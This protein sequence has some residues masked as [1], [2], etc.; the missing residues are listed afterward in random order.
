MSDERKRATADVFDR[1]AG[2]YDQLGVDFFTPMGRD[3][4]DRAELRPG[5]R[6][7]DL[8][9]GRGAVTFAAAEAVG[10]DG[11]VCAIDIAPVMVELLRAEAQERGLPSVRVSVDD[12][13]APEF[14]PESFDALL[15]GLVMFFL[16]D[17][18]SALKRHAALLRP[19]GRLAFTTFAGNDPGFDAA[20]REVGRFVPDPLPP[21]DERQ[22][23]FGTPESIDALLTDAG[24][25]VANSEVVDYV[26]RFSSADHWLSWAWSHGGRYVLERVPESDLPAAGDAAK[27]A[28]ESTRT[29]DGDHAITTSIRFTVA[30]MP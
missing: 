22:G 6:V 20:M 15:G 4:V 9:A 5:E 13:D 30:R 14:A 19:S 25:R 27:A 18:S 16:A 11:E 8:G 7:L 12:A 26:S 29:P 3:L 17:P 1:A 2:T 10:A 21:R 24:F 23:P 28:F